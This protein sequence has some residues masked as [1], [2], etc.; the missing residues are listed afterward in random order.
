VIHLFSCHSRAGGNPLLAT[1][2]ILAMTP[3]LLHFACYFSR[4][5]TLNE[6]N[7]MLHKEYYVY[8]LASKR[9][10]T[11]YTGMTNDLLSRIYLHK[12]NLVSGFTKMYGVH[13]LVY[14]EMHNDVNE[15]I[16]REKQIKKWNRGWKINLIEQNNP[17]W[18]DLYFEL[19]G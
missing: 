18:L 11:I 4:L 12:K 6:N 3:F 19:I 7:H 10:G 1:T 8:I 2:I 16:L 13:N 9:Y 5:L 17:R 14:F 15:A